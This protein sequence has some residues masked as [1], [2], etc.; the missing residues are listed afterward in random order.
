MAR[1]PVFEPIL[2]KP[3]YHKTSYIDFEWY[4]GFAITQKR[5]SIQSLHDAFLS[6]FNQKGKVLEISTKSEDPLGAQLSAFRLSIT[7]SGRKKLTL[8][9]SYQRGKVFKDGYKP[10]DEDDLKQIRTENRRHTISGFIFNGLSFPTHPESLFYDW[11]Y[12]FYLME[13]PQL[14]QDLIK[15]NFLAFSDIEFNPKKSISTQA[16]SIAIFVS[17]YKNGYLNDV[18]FFEKEIFIPFYLKNIYRGLL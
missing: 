8:E 15:G 16:R 10:R 18:S 12:W 2:D 7:S 11:L 14:I 5:K 13:N 9:E 3:P 6:K 4:P 1:R 17:L